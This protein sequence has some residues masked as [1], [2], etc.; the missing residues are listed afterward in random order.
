MSSDSYF[1]ID[2]RDHSYSQSQSGPFDH[3]YSSTR[4]TQALSDEVSR[5]SGSKRRLRLGPRKRIK[6]IEDSMVLGQLIA[7]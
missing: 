1:L 5:E 2:V 6:K 7:L 3:S 4:S